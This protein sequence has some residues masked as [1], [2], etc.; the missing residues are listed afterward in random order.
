MTMARPERL[1]LRVGTDGSVT[2]ETKNVFG[3]R[4][5]DYITILEDLLEAQ[6]VTSTYTADYARNVADIA[7]N[8]EARNELGGS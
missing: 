2:A 7:A 8:E 6:A 1:V 4:C 5:L 3:A